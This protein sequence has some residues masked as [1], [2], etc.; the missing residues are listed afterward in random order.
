MAQAVIDIALD[1]IYPIHAPELTGREMSPTVVYRQIG[2]ASEE[3]LGRDMRGSRWQIAA[4]AQ[5]YDTAYDLG[6]A[7]EDTLHKFH[8]PLGGLDGPRC[9]IRVSDQFDEIETE[10][11]IYALIGEYEILEED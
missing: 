6:Q 1:R 2:L 3:T 9:A 5:D 4:M 11:G 8:G 7:I 10:L